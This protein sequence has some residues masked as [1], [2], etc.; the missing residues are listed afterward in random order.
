[1]MRT[2]LFVICSLLVPVALSAQQA[3]FTK[4][5][6]AKA[7]SVAACYPRH[8]VTDPKTLSDKLT[9]SLTTDAEKFRAIYTWVCTNIASDY[10]LFRLNQHQ[11]NKLKDDAAALDAWRR[12]FS[13]RV[14]QV[15]GRHHRTV[16]TGYAYL[17]RELARH[18]GI[19]CVIVDGYG[20][21]VQANIRGE[22]DVNHSWNAVQLDGQWYLCD[23]TWSSGAIDPAQGIFIKNYDDRYFLADPAMFVRNH[24]PV[25]TAY[26]LLKDKPSLQAFLYAPLIYGNIYKYKAMPVSPSTFD[27]EVVKGETVMFQLEGEAVGSVTVR[28]GSLSE[29]VAVAPEGDD[30]YCFDYTFTARGRHV[31]HV[32]IDALYAWTYT[33][34]VR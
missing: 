33:V 11:S 9:R 2:L 16:C 7:D 10:S 26:M 12:Q 28:S 27:V 14:F 6:W 4:L 21:T 17:L 19:R 22:G 30:R 5:H 32:L 18:A 15:L 20:R 1:M 29:D 25:D 34:Q 13:R 23:A 24:Y 3:H 8:A 31:V